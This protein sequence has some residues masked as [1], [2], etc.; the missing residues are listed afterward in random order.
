M[1]VIKILVLKND[2]PNRNG[3]YILYYR[4][5]YVAHQFQFYYMYSSFQACFY[6]A[7]LRT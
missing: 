6:I 4:E 7:V 1:V 3:L 2:P 5:F